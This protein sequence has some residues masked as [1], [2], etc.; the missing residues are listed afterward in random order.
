MVRCTPSPLLSGH[1]GL[2]PGS[3]DEPLVRLRNGPR[4]KAGATERRR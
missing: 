1:P 3:I 4:L 2:E